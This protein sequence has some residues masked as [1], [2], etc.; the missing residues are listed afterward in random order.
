MDKVDLSKTRMEERCTDIFLGKSCPFLRREG[1]ENALCS[2]GFKLKRDSHVTEHEWGFTNPNSR[3]GGVDYV[4]HYIHRRNMECVRLDSRLKKVLAGIVDLRDE[5]RKVLAAEYARR[6]EFQPGDVFLSRKE[7]WICVYAYF[8]HKVVRVEVD[9]DDPN[10]RYPSYFSVPFSITGNKLKETKFVASC[11]YKV[12]EKDY[13][14]KTH[15]LCK[16]ENG[17]LGIVEK[18]QEKYNDV[19]LECKKNNIEICGDWPGLRA[20]VGNFQTKQTLA[21]A[22]R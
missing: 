7:L 18:E 21:K 11:M 6:A 14:S 19:P 5:Y 22:K 20:A 9:W 10:A 8:F 2:I 16:K 4:R 1:T 3:L 12:R 17:H 13:S 15:F